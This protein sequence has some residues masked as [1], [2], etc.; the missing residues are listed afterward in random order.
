[1]KDATNNAVAWTPFAI[2]TVCGKYIVRLAGNKQHA[3]ERFAAEK[4]G[5]LVQSVKPVQ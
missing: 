4:R 3:L 5:L 2:E 1:M